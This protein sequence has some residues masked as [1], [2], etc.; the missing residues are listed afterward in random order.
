MVLG[1]L[2]EM[3]SI[4]LVVPSIAVMVGRPELLDGVGFLEPFRNA[5]SGGLLAVGL[6]IILATYLVKTA[7]LAFMLWQQ[8]AFLS[9]LH[10]EISRRLYEVYLRQPWTFHLQRN[11]AGLICNLDKVTT[12]T[13]TV[14]WTLI[15]IAELLVLTGIMALL[16]WFEPLGAI[17]VGALMVV[18][19]LMLDRLMKRRL[20][21]WGALQ[22]ERE[23][24][25]SKHMHQGVHGVKEAMIRGPEGFL[26]QFS[27]ANAAYS[28][29][30]SKRGFIA[31]LPR[32]WYEL[33]AVAALCTLTAVMAAQGKSP[34]AMLPVLG[35]F[36]VA[37]F[38][39]LPSVNRLATAGHVLRFS[40]PTIQTIH[41]ELAFEHGLPPL[42]STAS[43]LPFE[44]A[45]VVQQVSYRYPDSK[46]A[47]VE[48]VDL[49]IP[50]GTSVGLVGS[51]GSGKSTLV[52]IILGLLS[53]TSGSVTVDGIDIATNLA[54][55]QRRVGYVPQ[56]I[57]LT[58]D[59]IRRNVAFGVPD[60]EIDD[61]AVFRALRAA[62]LEGF[63]DSLPDRLDAVVGERGVRLSGGQRQRIGIARALY[64]DPHTLLLDEA[65]SALDDE[66]E[67][68]VTEAVN[69]LHG[70]KT[71][72][73]VAHR[74]TTV[75]NC[76][77]IYRLEAGRI[78]HTGHRLEAAS[79]P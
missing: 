38:R 61:A 55:W 2:L 12:V 7:V 22:E 35:L 53:P 79:A 49:R 29:M 10:A 6:G 48:A 67:R 37:A 11:S 5:P 28:R 1:M 34:Q 40:Q 4:G 52:D 9:S 69:M 30:A 19:T 45:L 42:T 77:T 56:A 27:E 44:S 51:S 72:V 66:T 43:P 31:A 15:F 13:D 25:R 26:R 8:H 75:A 74:L 76:D 41:D 20:L 70:V 68:G 62:Q 36:A 24:V 58:D 46:S 32:L 33:V 71:L 3:L 39:I 21:I 14:A 65:T 64:H 18:A 16:V 73:I 63:V 47:A 54:G 50:A 17:A 57:Y 23:T 60:Q 78:V 59:T